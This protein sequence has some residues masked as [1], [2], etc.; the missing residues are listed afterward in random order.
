MAAKQDLTIKQGSTFNRV[1]RWESPPYIYKAITGITKA[2]PAVVTATGHGVPDG[3]RVAIAS[4]KGMTQINATNSPPKA[5][6][7][8]RATV[9]N[10]N[11]IE[12]NEV[13]SLDYGT[14]TGNTGTLIYMTP[15]DL[16]GYTARMT[17][18]DKIGGTVLASTEIAHDPLDVIT[19]TLNNT[20]KTITIS[21]PSA[22]TTAFTW[23]SG[24]YDLEMVSGTGVVT[25]LIY[26]K[27]TVEKEVTT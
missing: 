12:L 13:N 2:A 14:H 23:V 8:L 26:G 7:F 5:A 20:D 11:E 21:I 27:V 18:R 10:A 24:V 16:A 17:I 3:W 22:D 1:L 25:D 19:I 6:D 9:K 4:V 15:V